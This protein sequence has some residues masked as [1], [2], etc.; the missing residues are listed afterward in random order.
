MRDINELDHCYEE[1]DERQKLEEE[2]R[3]WKDCYWWAD[4][5]KDKSW[6][7]KVSNDAR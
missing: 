5:D 1:A 2:E 3:M 4:E 7:S 6:I